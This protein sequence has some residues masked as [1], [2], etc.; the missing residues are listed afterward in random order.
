MPEVM[1]ISPEGAGSE[2]KPEDDTPAAIS[3][4][5]FWTLSFAVR[6]SNDAHPRI[7]ELVFRIENATKYKVREYI[8]SPTKLV[9]LF[10]YQVEVYPM[11]EITQ[12]LNVYIVSVP[13]DGTGLPER[14]QG[15][16]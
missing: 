7:S 10:N 16:A 12:G 9:E 5:T 6:P 2:G 11:G 8:K 4:K 14:L 1:K 3:A 13:M 15:L